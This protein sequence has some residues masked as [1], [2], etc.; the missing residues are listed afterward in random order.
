MLTLDTLEIQLGNSGPQVDTYRSTT[1]IG[2]HSSIKTLPEHNQAVLGLLSIPGNELCADC[3]SKGTALADNIA[4]AACVLENEWPFTTVLLLLIRLHEM[5]DPEWC[6]VNL[7][8]FICIECS[9]IHRNLGSH[10]S[11]VQ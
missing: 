1:S 5:T 11:K 2:G 6:S 4:L 3:N 8:I 9:G 7:G 10:I